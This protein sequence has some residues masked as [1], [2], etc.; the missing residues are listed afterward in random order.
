MSSTLSEAR[1]VPEPCLRKLVLGSA[2][3]LLFC[4]ALLI[5]AMPLAPFLR[6]LLLLLWMLDGA[7]E[8]MRFVR[9]RR[10]V[11]ELVV[12]EQGTITG[13]DA[14]GRAY[15]LT[16]LSGS[17]VLSRIAWLRLRFADKCQ[18]GE[19]IRATADKERQWHALQVIWRQAASRFGL[20]R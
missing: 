15:D 9:G 20:R 6:A 2:G 16:L 8:L 17:L 13:T 18:Y 3:L 4:G 1:L 7:R 12:T 10:R 5:I 19:L 11:A 14:D